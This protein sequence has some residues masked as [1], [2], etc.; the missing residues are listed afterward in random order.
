MTLRAPVLALLL[1]GLAPASPAS[2][3]VTRTPSPAPSAQPSMDDLRFLRM[4]ISAGDLSSAESILQVHRAEK[5]EDAEYILGLAWLARGAALLGDW[6]AASEYA[7]AAREIATARLGTP[8]DYAANRESAYALGTAIEVEA[9]ALVASGRKTEAIAFLE[10]SSRAQAK[11]PYNLR[12]RIWKR[13]NQIEL[14]GQKAPDLRAEDHVGGAFPGLEALRGKPVVLFFWW[15]SCGDCKAQAAALR[16][17]VEKYASKGV[18]FVAPTRFYDE[19]HAEDKAKIEKAWREVYALPDSIAVPISDE[20]MLRY[21]VSAT[22]T[23]A[24]VDRKGVV[25]QYLPFR[26]TDERLSAAIEDLLK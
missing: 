25:R 4:K 26:M 6:T 3:Q 21:G 11:A 16:R 9:Q 19:D 18:V 10:E 12:A 7:K 20:A 22:P 13:R 23:F 8:A 17:A 1:A 14:V 2:A 5:G 24:F 15:E